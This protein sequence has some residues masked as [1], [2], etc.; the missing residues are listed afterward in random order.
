MVFNDD[1]VVSNNFDNGNEDQ[2]MIVIVIIKNIYFIKI[3]KQVCMKEEGI[4]DCSYI[5]ISCG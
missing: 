3:Y 1:D 4:G 2:K 5:V